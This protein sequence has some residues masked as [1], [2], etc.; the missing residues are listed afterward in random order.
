MELSP[1]L[2]SSDGLFGDG[3]ESV[4]GKWTLVFGVL[5]SAGVGYI[6][7]SEE[8]SRVGPRKWTLADY[9][10]WCSG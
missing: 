6:A 3:G 10:P 2:T 1:R 8:D 9:P 7:D 4:L 5:L